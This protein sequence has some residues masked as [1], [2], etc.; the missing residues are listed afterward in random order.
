ML[1][2]FIVIVAITVSFSGL[3]VFF[4][5]VLYILALVNQSRP[6]NF[7][8]DDTHVVVRRKLHQT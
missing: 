4:T 8:E 2:L 3:D 5:D 1:R 6:S 7:N